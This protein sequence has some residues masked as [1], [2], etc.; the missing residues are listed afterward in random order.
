MT[1]WEFTLLVALGSLVAGFLGSLTG[2]GGGVVLVPM[3]VIFFDIDVRYAFG[4]SLVAVIATSSGSAAAFVRQG[5][6]NVRLALIL[7]VA[8]TFGGLTGALLLAANLL[9]PMAL[10]TVFGLVLLLTALLAFRPRNPREESPL[11][12]ATDYW[13]L[14][15]VCP[16]PVGP[17]AYH[18]YKIPL[19]FGLMYVVGVLSGLLGIGAGAFKVL[20]MD[21]VLRVPFKVATTTSNFMTGVTAGASLGIYIAGGL[22]D[23]TLA[24]PVIFGVLL[25]SVLGARVLVSAPPLVLRWIFGTLVL[26]LALQMIY[27]GLKGS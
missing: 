4:A 13:D 23:P 27:R 24:M 16:T 17:R 10:S 18:V 11:D 26:V 9:P 21:Q 1:V 25:G 6:V 19:G 22:L 20:T 14:D 8:T 15:G 7:E 3:L 5:Y 2:L 12:P